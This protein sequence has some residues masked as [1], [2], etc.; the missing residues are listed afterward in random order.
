MNRLLC[1]VAALVMTAGTVAFATPAQAVP[2]R[3][4]VR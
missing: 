3:Q 4:V 2:A 1:A